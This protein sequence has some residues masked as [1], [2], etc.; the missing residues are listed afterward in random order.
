MTEKEMLS[1]ARARIKELKAE[2]D[3]YQLIVKT[4]GKN[5]KT[6]ESINSLKKKRTISKLTIIQKVIHALK[7]VDEPLTSRDIMLAVNN[8]YPD[9]KQYDMGS[10]SGAFSVAY[11]KNGIIKY[12]LE[13]PTKDVKAVYILKDWKKDE[14]IFNEYKNKVK[15]RYGTI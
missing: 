8:K 9:E 6:T 12:D 15:K 1:F 7:E 10:F 14:A 11:K 5:G 4:F 3:K 2:M 13:N